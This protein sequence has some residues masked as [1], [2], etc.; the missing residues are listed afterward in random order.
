MNYKD[1]MYGSL[2]RLRRATLRVLCREYFEQTCFVLVL[3][4]AFLQNKCE[5]VDLLSRVLH[6]LLHHSL[7]NYFSIH[8]R[9]S[10]RPSRLHE[11]ADSIRPWL[12][13]FRP[14]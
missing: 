4:I 9:L 6:E 10:W 3:P 2:V 11:H 7:V 8:V 5:C 14:A 12:P 13:T 1:I